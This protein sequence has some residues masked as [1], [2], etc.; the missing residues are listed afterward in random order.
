MRSVP[1]RETS[2]SMIWTKGIY[3][4]IT[5]ST[6]TGEYLS[7]TDNEHSSSTALIQCG[8][9]WSDSDVFGSVYWNLC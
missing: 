5:V 6:S 9:I 2:V 3:L 4:T 1:L 8:C 7:G